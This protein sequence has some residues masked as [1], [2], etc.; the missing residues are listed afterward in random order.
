[1]PAKLTLFPA[2]GT[3]R[4]FV[5]REGKNHFVG[6][7]PSSDLLLDDPRVSARHALLQWTG[8]DWILV[9]LRS[10]NG[11]FVNGAPIT[12]LPLQNHDWISFGGL[13][14]RIERVSENEI[15]ALLSERARRLQRFVEARHDLEEGLAPRILLQRLLESA[16]DLVDADRGFVFLV[17]PTGEIDAQLAAGFAP[18]EPIDSRLQAGLA[19]TESVLRTGEAAVVSDS[20]ALSQA[21]RRRGSDSFAGRALA[22]IALKSGQRVMGLIWVEGRKDGGVFTELDLEILEALADHAA[23]LLDNLALDRPIRELVGVSPVAPPA[24]GRPFLD[25]LEA[26][27][28]AIARG[29]GQETRPTV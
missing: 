4:T 16:L 2:R 3:S 15:E 18:F 8:N 13:A 20:E 22:C 1:V 24:A 10:K 14:A 5:F 19:E 26:R 9:D 21:G 25:E 7:D 6:R 28:S 27:M 29:V 11:T 17:Q 23:L 12:E